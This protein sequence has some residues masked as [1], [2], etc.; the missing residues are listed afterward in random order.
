MLSAK[1]PGSPRVDVL[2]GIRI[3]ATDSLDGAASYYKSILEVDSTNVVCRNRT[4][5]AHF[6]HPVQAAWKRLITVIRRQGNIESAVKEL[7]LFLDTF[8][9]DAEGWLELADIYSSCSQWV[10]IFLPFSESDNS[11]RHTYALQSLTHVMLL[12]PQN[13]FY[14][15]QAAE[16][17]YAAGDVPL[18]ARLFLQAVDLI[19]ED[20]ARNGVKTSAP[21]GVAIRSWYGLRLVGLCVFTSQPN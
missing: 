2:N 7:H 18:S 9:T 21:A 19:D 1:F 6:T 11:Y 4:R 14:I 8:Y 13:P 10:I 16:T 12:V 17:A 20:S 15:V 5:L 3:E